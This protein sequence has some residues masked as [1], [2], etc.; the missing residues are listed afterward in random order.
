MGRHRVQIDAEAVVGV[1][2]CSALATGLELLGVIGHGE[3]TGSPHAAA[4]R[5][6]SSPE[7]E[8]HAKRPGSSRGDQQRRRGSTLSDTT[9]D[10]SATTLRQAMTS[11]MV[12]AGMIRSE[13]VEAT[14]ATVPRH[15]FAPE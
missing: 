10:D 14:F 8:A 5:A 6:A 15:R 4:G 13:P 11:D 9:T 12:K 7:E 3:I 1:T 2:W